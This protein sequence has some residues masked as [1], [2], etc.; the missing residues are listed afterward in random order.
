MSQENVDRFLEGIEA[1]NRGDV[2]LWLE[3]SH[4]DVLEVGIAE[5]RST[6]ETTER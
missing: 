3:T 5:S 1:F 2:A 6:D 4:P